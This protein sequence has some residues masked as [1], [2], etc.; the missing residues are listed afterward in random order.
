MRRDL[1]SRI[2]RLE[3][4]LAP[5]GSMQIFPVY[6]G[7]TMDEAQAIYEAGGGI[8][9]PNDLVIARTVYI[10]RKQ[11]E[12]LEATRAAIRAEAERQRGAA[13]PERPQQRPED[14]PQKGNRM[15]PSGGSSWEILK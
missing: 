6:Q 1:L 7:E 11:S 9:G 10:T 14:P 8:I 12:N 4:E 13:G 2:E 3:A 15:L 5:A